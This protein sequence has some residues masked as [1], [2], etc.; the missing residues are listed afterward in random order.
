MQIKS[1]QRKNDK[2][3]KFYILYHSLGCMNP[4]CRFV[5]TYPEIS[6]KEIADYIRTHDRSKELELIELESKILD[7]AAVIGM[8]EINGWTPRYILEDNGFDLLAD[9]NLFELYGL[10]RKPWE[11]KTGLEVKKNPGKLRAKLES[12]NFVHTPVISYRTFRGW[13]PAAW[14]NIQVFGIGR[15]Y[16]E[17]EAL[18]QTITECCFKA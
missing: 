1:R 15:Y 10:E 7:V 8:V 14:D 16:S 9:I 11:F 13:R 3:E 18:R 17:K 4:N 12:L 2:P 5:F 6:S